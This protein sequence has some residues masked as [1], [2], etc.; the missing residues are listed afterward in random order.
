M[1]MDVDID[2]AVKA[3]LKAYRV[4]AMQYQLIN[5]NVKGCSRSN[6]KRQTLSV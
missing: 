6:V 5:E 4:L 2:M 3:D 1:R